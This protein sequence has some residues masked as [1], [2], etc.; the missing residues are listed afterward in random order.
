MG[1]FIGPISGA[2]DTPGIGPESAIPEC[3][4][5]ELE[6]YRAHPWVSVSVS[7]SKLWVS[8]SFRNRVWSRVPSN[9]CLPSKMVFVIGI[10][11]LLHC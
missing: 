2:G 11:L 7:E 6:S 9:P 8:V 4:E 1:T 3:L 10:S 5:S